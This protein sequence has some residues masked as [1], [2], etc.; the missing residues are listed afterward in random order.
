MWEGC[1]RAVKVLWEGGSA[2]GWDPGQA[3]TQRHAHKDGTMSPSLKVLV[4][5]EAHQ[6]DE[7]EEVPELLLSLSAWLQTLLDL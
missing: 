4:V 2:W 7:I 5:A 3:D 6:A 1:E